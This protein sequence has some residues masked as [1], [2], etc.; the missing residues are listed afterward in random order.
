[1]THEIFCVL[2]QQE[3]ELTPARAPHFG[4]HHFPFTVIK[5][6]FTKALPILSQREVRITLSGSYSYESEDEY[7]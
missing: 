6:Y 4:K 7:Y 2:E 5:H 1:V 3:H